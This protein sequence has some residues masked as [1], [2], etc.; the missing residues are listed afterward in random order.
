M[1]TPPGVRQLLYLVPPR[2]RLGPLG[3][4]AL[5]PNFAILQRSAFTLLAKKVRTELVSVGAIM[6]RWHD[7]KT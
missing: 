2:I 1:A 3:G 4:L 7:H 5:S 6:Q